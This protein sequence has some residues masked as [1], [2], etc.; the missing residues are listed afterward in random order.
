MGFVRN[1]RPWRIL[2]VT[3]EGQ[4]EGLPLPLLGLTVHSPL[5]FLRLVSLGLSE[6]L[7][8]LPEARGANQGLECSTPTRVAYARTHA[9]T[10]A[11]THALSC[12]G[13]TSQEKGE[14]GQPEDQQGLEGPRPPFSTAPYSFSTPLAP[15]A[16][17]NPVIPAPR[18]PSSPSPL[19]FYSPLDRKSVV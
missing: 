3:E 4:E 16:S 5:S 18:P 1:L 17:E 15:P 13:P 8:G 14:P 11:Y 10:H 12:P 7:P 19:T 6:A 9:R 2:K